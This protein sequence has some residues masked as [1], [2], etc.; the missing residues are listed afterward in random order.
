LGSVEKSPKPVFVG[1]HPWEEGTFNWFRVLYDGGRF[2]C[3]YNA[4]AIDTIC[5][6]TRQY[7]KV[8]Y[9]ESE[10]G[11]HW[12]TPELG[13]IEW[14]GSRNNNL[15]FDAARP[16]GWLADGP[17]PFV[18]PTARPEE[19]YKMV[20]VDSTGSPHTRLMLRGAYSPDGL[21][22][23]RYPEVFSPKFHDTQNVATYDP[24]LGKYVAYVRGAAYYGGIALPPDPIP[25]ARRGRAI[26][27]MES[28]DFHDW[29]S[30]E[31]C[32]EPDIADPLDM[33]FY[34]NAYSFYPWADRVHF[35]FPA[36]FHAGAQKTNIQVAV[37]RD[38][39][40]WIRPTREVLINNGVKG[41]YDEGMI[42]VTPGIVDIG[43]DRLALYTQVA[44]L[45]KDSLVRQRSPYH[46][47]AMSRV[48]FL[49][50]RIIGIEAGVE[51]GLFSTRDLIFEGG[52]LDM[53]VEPTRPN[54]QLRVEL[55]SAETNKVC[56]GY[57]FAACDPITADRVNAVA[58]WNG[59]AELGEW[60]KKPVRL[61]F[62]L[63]SIRIYAIQFLG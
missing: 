21:H 58:T 3:W 12:R 40:H 25:R 20:Y 44:S 29:S 63:L 8:A 48:T 55:V 35:M 9:A 37:S 30:P 24:L 27:R 6:H 28:E 13:L 57:E 7:D 52:R 32:I 10:D 38:N 53:N 50:D 17:A 51:E 60:A 46:G 14:N 18:D 15:V 11:I 22:W 5:G 4:D 56:P 2:R 23:Q 62:K 26:W 45:G 19:R 47:F 42:Y 33:D 43:N 36:A 34:T 49:R 31:S 54:G 59:K 16:D 39:Q 1:S 41:S 61:R